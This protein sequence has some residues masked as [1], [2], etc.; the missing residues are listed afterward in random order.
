MHPFTLC[1]GYKFLRQYPSASPMNLGC[2][3][4]AIWG[5]RKFVGRVLAEAHMKKKTQ[6]RKHA[7]INNAVL[8]A[9]RGDLLWTTHPSPL[10]SFPPALP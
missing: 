3:Y 5:T 6:E 7:Q 2:P 10:I 1:V 4:A 8:N 9:S